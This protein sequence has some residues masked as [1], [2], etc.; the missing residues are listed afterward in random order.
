MNLE[1]PFKMAVCGNLV[2]VGDHQGIVKF[3]NKLNADA[4]AAIQAHEEAITALQIYK[5]RFYTASR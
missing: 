4:E 1:L 5:G 2:A 3:W